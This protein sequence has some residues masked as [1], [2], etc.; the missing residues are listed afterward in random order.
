MA[1]EAGAARS[2]SR[3]SAAR[4]AAPQGA[5]AGSTLGRRGAGA[6]R[7]ELKADCFPVSL[8]PASCTGCTVGNLGAASP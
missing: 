1:A 3:H 2:P 7:Q 8:S 4:A 5:G 6:Q